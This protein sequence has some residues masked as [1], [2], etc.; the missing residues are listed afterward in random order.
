MLRVFLIT[1]GVVAVAAGGLVLYASATQPD[2]FRIQRSALINAPQETVHGILSDLRRG[3][4]WSPYEKKDPTMKKSFSG[5]ATG[6]GAMME[7]DGNNDIGAGKLT[8]ANATPSKITINLD[9]IKPMAA[10]NVVEYDLAPQGNATN[11]TWSMHGPMTIFSKV[12]CTFMNMDRMV[13][14][15]FEQGLRDLKALAER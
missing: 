9:M 7:W 11:L 10:S 8:I 6:P 12:L 3:A 5:P 4:E 13:G 14:S 1:I 15:D 2:T